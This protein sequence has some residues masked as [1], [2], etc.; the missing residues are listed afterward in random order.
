MP[1]AHLLTTALGLTAAWEVTGVR[2]DPEAGRMDLNVAF[3]KGS[4]F[5]CPACGVQGQPVHDTR[6]HIWQQL[7]LL[8]YTLYYTFVFGNCGVLRWSSSIVSEP[9][10]RRPGAC[11]AMGRRVGAST[12]YATFGHSVEPCQTVRAA[13]VL[14]SRG[15]MLPEQGKRSRGVPACDN[16]NG[17]Y[18]RAASLSRR[19]CAGRTWRA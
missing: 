13:T 1:P 17:S 14:L 15:P 8:H 12:S 6:E 11:L 3:A 5:A 16:A 9:Q 18:G 10:T 4:R 19:C 7:T 2:F